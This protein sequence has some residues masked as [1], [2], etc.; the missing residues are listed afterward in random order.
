M[1]DL[2]NKKM[3]KEWQKIETAGIFDSLEEFAKYYYENGEKSCFR[4]ITNDPW[5]KE[6]FFFGTYQELLEFYKNEL[7]KRSIG[8]KYH[9][10][11][12]LD[13]FKE[14]KEGKERWYAKCQCDC[15]NETVKLF[16]S[17]KD[18]NAR[19]CGCK[20]GKAT[21]KKVS[22][23]DLFPKIVDQY[24]DFEKNSVLPED[25]SIDSEEEFWWNG[26][27][28]SYKM[29]IHY[30]LKA[31]PGTSFPEQSI[32]FFLTMNNIEVVSRHL[33]TYNSKKYELDLFLPKYNIG[34]EYDGVFW[35]SEKKEKDKLKNEAVDNS[36]ITF[37]RIRE[38]GLNKTGTKNGLEIIMKEAV[39]N[40]SLAD[41][42]NELF[43]FLETKLSLKLEKISAKDISSNKLSIQKQYSLAFSK[44]SIVNSWLSVFWSSK[45]TVEPYLVNT[46]SSEQ[47]YFVCEHGKEFYT[48]PK[49]L[50]ARA[51]ELR[52][53]DNRKCFF[54]SSYLCYDCDGVKP[55]IDNVKFVSD[56]S[57][58]IEFSVLNKTKSSFLPIE[59]GFCYTLFENSVYLHK[60]NDFCINEKS[61]VSEFPPFSKKE[62]SVSLKLIDDVITQNNLD[63]IFSLNLRDQF[64]YEYKLCININKKETQYLG[65]AKICVPNAYNVLLGEKKTGYDFTNNNFKQSLSG[66]EA[67]RLSNEIKIYTEPKIKGVL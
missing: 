26:Y 18:G 9:S 8:R 52:N 43:S 67:R 28:S 41:A 21:T 38:K 42:I 33:I 1:I 27:A 10:L 32:R 61:G 4:I 37:I 62:Y 65:H 55:F 29:P 44:D 31:D 51:R 2:T 12:V 6:N 20:Q 58:V 50:L 7:P 30:L 5:S 14:N 16:E 54:D 46:D 34:I 53:K 35:H 3:L 64:E 23:Y 24:W 56:N 11:T 59:S 60:R 15:G 49:F 45:N 48:S 57:L 17:L 39:S 66:T 63:V 13:V 47:C 19:T 36:N 40:R 22:L 25:V